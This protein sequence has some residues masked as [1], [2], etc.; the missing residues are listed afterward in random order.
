MLLPI[1]IITRITVQHGW[2]FCEPALLSKLLEKKAGT[3]RIDTD[4][5]IK[6][7]AWF[8]LSRVHHIV[9][10]WMGMIKSR[11]IIPHSPTNHG[12]RTT[13]HPERCNRNWYQLPW[14]FRQTNNL[15]TDAVCNQWCVRITL[16]ML[17][18]NLKPDALYPCYSIYHLYVVHIIMRI[19]LSWFT[20]SC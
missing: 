2:E 10:G 15:T 5:R 7:W 20:N 4:T 14:F 16:S 13:P 19:Y 3:T 12:P 1:Q 17:T 11:S 6:Y 8:T 18:K 9:S